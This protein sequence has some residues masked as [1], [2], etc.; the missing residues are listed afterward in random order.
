M[1]LSPAATNSSKQHSRNK[2]SFSSSTGFISVIVFLFWQTVQV[3]CASMA[4]KLDVVVDRFRQVVK[5]DDEDFETS[6]LV[7][8]LWS[9]EG[10]IRKYGQSRIADDFKS[11]IKKVEAFYYNAPKD[12]NRDSV[13][14]L[15]SCERATGC[16]P[17][18]AQLKDHSA[19][20]GLL[21]ICRNLAF[22]S[23]MYM[24][25]LDFDMDTLK[26]AQTAYHS[27]LRPHH[28]WALRKFYTLGLRVVTPHRRG[29]FAAMG[30]YSNPKDFDAEA[31]IATEESLRS[32]LS[33]FEPLLLRARAIYA[34]V[35]F[36]D[37]P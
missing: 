34:K 29:M 13:A 8:A 36:E 19:A 15:L 30:G 16:H 12:C 5:T 28:C 1:A 3:K 23:E 18:D 14:N 22:Q 7:Q 27:I 25:I 35:G 24:L 6:S 32:L 2:N 33:I 26:A 17:S 37:T 9:Y 11:N 31:E 4:G 21:W 20:M 10:H